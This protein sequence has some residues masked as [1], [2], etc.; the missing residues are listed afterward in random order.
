MMLSIQLLILH[1]YLCEIGGGTTSKL[2]NLR[3]VNQKK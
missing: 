1:A 2:I 3:V